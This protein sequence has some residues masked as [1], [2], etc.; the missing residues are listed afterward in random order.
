MAS[1]LPFQFI[2]A[3]INP[4]V[5]G[6]AGNAARIIEIVQVH[7]KEGNIIVF[8]EL[9]LSGY[10]PEDLILNTGF[11]D[12]IDAQ[13]DLILEQTKDNSAAFILPTP[14]RQ[15][16]KTYNAAHLIH[17]G[18]IIGTALKHHLPNYGVFD[19][20]RVFESAEL[21]DAIDF[22]GHKIGL[23]ICEDMWFDDVAS[24]LK[25]QDAEILIAPHGS[26]YCAG[27]IDERLKHASARSQENNLPLIFV[28]QIG[29]QD[30]LVFDGTS[31]SLNASG[32]ITH[33]C[34][35]FE[36]EITHISFDEEIS[37]QARNP[38]E[39]FYRAIA[40]GIR[41]YVRKNGFE[42][43]LL[44]LS[45]GVDSALVA[46]L[47]V[48]ALGAQHV[49]AYM[50]PS[51]FTSQESL[52]DAAALADNL[53]V[54]LQNIS[55]EEPLKGF[56]TA[57]DNP[58]GLTH[59]NLQSR[60]R[61]SLLMALSNHS[62][63]LLLTTGNKSEMATGYA[64]LYGDMNGA[65]NPIKDV[66]KTMVYELCKWRNKDG[67]VIPE[68]ILTKA[69]SAELRDDQTDQD[70]LPDYDILDGILHGLIEERLS[71]DDL[72]ERGFNKKTV[73]KVWALLDRSEYKRFQSAPGPKVTTLSF[74]RNRRIPMTNGYLKTVEKDA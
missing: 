15:K 21:G 73:M 63:A 28:N 61:G 37:P 58:D 60:V 26:P 25:Q 4:V 46:A 50:L 34:V 13:I 42:N 6:I 20:K 40:L 67:L 31:F 7:D 27:K 14:F 10:P 32:Q 48:D 55:I 11:L 45:G 68:R 29:G 66:Y 43:V 9:V 5:G 2:I 70:S 24:H 39:D 3:Q 72:T 44:G 16:G 71:L 64:T 18:E 17:G 69:P 1:S 52:D 30:E 22:Q 23:M 47:A 54:S 8:S 12:S 41:D 59:E 51:R 74:G 33:Q 36:E 57:L 49:K 56:E 53:G 62:G 38:H 35:S 65:Y 19:E